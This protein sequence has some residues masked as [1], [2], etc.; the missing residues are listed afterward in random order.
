MKKSDKKIEKKPKNKA[1]SQ[2]MSDENKMLLKIVLLFLIFGSILCTLIFGSIYVY[3]AVC[4]ENSNYLL[5]NVRVASNGFW[6]GRDKIITRHLKLKTGRDNIFQLDLKKIQ[7]N[8]LKL[9][10]VKDCEISRIL[11]DMLQIHLIERMPRARIS[12]YNSYLVDEDGIILMKRYCLIDSQTLPIITGFTPSTTLQSN[13]A[14]PELFNAMQIITMTLRYYSDIEILAVDVK[15]KDFLRF[16][17]RYN[18]GKLRQA[19]MPNS[20]NGIDIRLKALRTAL[21]RS[22]AAED[23]TSVYNLSFDGRVICQ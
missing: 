10:G 11:P 13:K 12:R 6:N 23:K 1:S 3:K 16:Y 9:P 15:D 4:T 19:I 2:P 20:L 21:I 18:R 22:H 7:E 14:V 5:R 8:A 17:V